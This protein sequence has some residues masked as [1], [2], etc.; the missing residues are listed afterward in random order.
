MP[1]TKISGDVLQQPIN[2]GVATVTSVSVGSAVTIDASG[3]NVTGVVTSSSGFIG[4]LTGNVT[5][6]LTGNVSGNATGL[7]ATPNIT[8]GS[9]TASSAT[10]SGITTL[11]SAGGITTAGGTLFAKQ[12]NISGV[13]TFGNTVVGGATTQLIV[14]G[15]A[16]ITGILTRLVQVV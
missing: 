5:G 1:L 6:N 3:I 16:R 10:I 15:N 2:V 7:S 14:N 8:V 12:L 11:A 4:N 13:S 9:I